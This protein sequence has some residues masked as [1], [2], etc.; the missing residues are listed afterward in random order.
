MFESGNDEFYGCFFHFDSGI[1]DCHRLLTDFVMGCEIGVDRGISLIKYV[2]SFRFKE[3][4]IV[5]CEVVHIDNIIC[6]T[7]SC[8]LASCHETSTRRSISF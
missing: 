7:R 2:V 4:I 5:V 1:H 6:C 8:G 3:L